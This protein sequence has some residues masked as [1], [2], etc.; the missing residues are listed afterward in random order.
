M[1]K[2]FYADPN[3][4]KKLPAGSQLLE[5]DLLLLTVGETLSGKTALVNALEHTCVTS[6]TW[7]GST[8]PRVAV[9]ADILGRR[10][11]VLD[12]NGSHGTS[13]TEIE[14]LVRQDG[15]LDKHHVAILC[16][17]NADALARSLPFIIELT[18]L[19]VPLL[20]G[21]RDCQNAKNKGVM[22]NLD[23][24]SN[25]LDLPILFCSKTLI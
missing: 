10:V 3:F 8:V 22:L 13:I 6:G 24:I 4:Y 25:I 2:D 5:D 16:V 18:E 20:L 9:D 19:G 1:A 14:E 15:V 12:M 21:L 11:R 17:M 7:P 23:V